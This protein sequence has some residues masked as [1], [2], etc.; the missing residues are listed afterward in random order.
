VSLA[1]IS[2]S[3]S[4]IIKKSPGDDT[5]P[6]PIPAGAKQPLFGFGVKS[7]PPVVTAPKPT[8]ACFVG[9]PEKE[10]RPTCLASTRDNA[11]LWGPTFVVFPLSAEHVVTAV[12]FSRK[13]N[14]CVSVLGTGHE[15]LNRHDGCP[16]GL[17]IRTTLMKDIAWDLEDAHG[18]GWKDGNVR[19]GTGLTF[20]E[21]G[22]SASENGRIMAEGWTHTVKK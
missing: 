19:L 3:A 20:S 2:L 9:S 18:F 11:A 5:L 16:D 14:L 21:I 4:R 10:T 6:A 1:I 12:N 22:K 15:F 13:H 7:M 17:L 8:G